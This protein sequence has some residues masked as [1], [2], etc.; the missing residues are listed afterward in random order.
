MSIEGSMRRL[1]VAALWMFLFCGE[2]RAQDP[3]AAQ[4]LRGNE[5]DLRRCLD[6][7]LRDNFE[8]RKAREQIEKQHGVLIEARSG[9][10]PRVSADAYYARV[11]QGLLPSLGG[12][13]FGTER[14]WTTE[15]RVT[16]PLFAGGGLVAAYAQQSFNEDAA[17]FA[18]QAVLNQI[19]FATRAAFY[20]VL[21][22]RAQLVVQEKNVKLLE[23]ELQS[24]KRKRD[25]GTVSDFNVLRADVAL[26]N[27]RTPLI[28]ARNRAAISV[29]E[30]EEVLG[31]KRMPVGP[32]EAITVRGELS[33]D[34]LEIAQ[35]EAIESALKDRPDLKQANLLLK[36]GDQGL[37]IARADYFPK[38]SAFGTYGAEKNQFAESGEDSLEGWQG[39]FQATWN[40]F[41]SLGREG[42]VTQALSDKK[43]LEHARDELILRIEVEVRRAWS[44]LSEARQLVEASRQVSVQAEESLRLAKARFDAG[45]AIQ[46]E[47][48][49][50]QVELTQARANEVQALH[51]YAL[52]R[53]EL[54][55]A[56]GRQT[57]S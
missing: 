53:A 10:L 23:E 43:L 13:A 25:A 22:S 30:L 3:A 9:L 17:R 35:Q 54:E 33:F 31:L 28:R 40:I 50:A 37:K 18:F 15:I 24:E 6:T 11:D 5:Y 21:V 56:I 34:P 51:D 27:S 47:V 41:D 55:R 52:V 44:Q 57:V 38:V 8:V 36:A 42:R 2:V 1:I 39:G 19:V 16:Q 48:L 7:A 14:M 46:L 4:E 20:R 45:V 32:R 12:Q 26:A 29:V 49:D